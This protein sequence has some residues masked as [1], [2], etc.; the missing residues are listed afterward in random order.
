MKKTI[1]ASF[2]V[3][4]ITTL[5][6][7]QDNIQP[8]NGSSFKAK[9]KEISKTEVKY[10]MIDN[11]DGPMY[12]LPLTDIDFIKYENGKIENYTHLKPQTEP[13][14]ITND[15]VFYEKRDTKPVV[16]KLDAKDTYLQGQEDASVFYRKYRSAAGWTCATTI[17][18]SPIIGIIPA[19]ATSLSPPAIYN[20]GTPNIE[21]LKNPEYN[22]GYMDFAKKKKRQKVWTNFGIGTA[23][24]GILTIIGRSAGQ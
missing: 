8:K 12:I 15:E 5:L 6:F 1:F 22:R 9:I 14:K 11:L 2:F 16:E 23:V 4:F 20:L 7:A 10:L 24:W 21:K 17:V 3:L 19:M 18:F 13:T